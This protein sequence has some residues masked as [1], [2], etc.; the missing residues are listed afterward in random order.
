M[1]GLYVAPPHGKLVYKGK[2]TAV[3]KDRPWPELVGEFYLVSD[4]C[5]NGRAY[6][7]ITTQQEGPFTADEFR[8]KFNSHRVSSKEQARWWPDG[9]TFYLYT[10]KDFN[11]FAVPLSVEVPAG[12]QTIMSDVKFKEGRTL[13]PWKVF[14]RDGKFCVYKINDD[15]E[16]VGEALGCH[17]SESQARSQ[18]AALYAAESKNDSNLTVTKC[19][20]IET[21][22]DFVPFGVTSFTEMD[23]IEAA[24]AKQAE[25]DKRTIQLHQIIDNIAA[26]PAV[27]DKKAALNTVTNEYVE[28]VSETIGHKIGRRLNS[29]MLAV[30][31]QLKEGL[32]KLRKWAGYDEDDDD[33]GSKGISIKVLDDIF[34][35]FTTNSFID[36]EGEIFT[37]DSIEKLVARNSTKEVKGQVWYRHLPGSKFAHT[38]FQGIQGRFLIE[39]HRFDDTPVGQAMKALLNEHPNG[40]PEVCPEGWGCSHGY[41]YDPQDR[42]DSVYEWFDKQ[43]TSVLPA[44]VASNPYTKLE[45]LSMDQK[46]REEFEKLVGESIANEALSG[47]DELTKAL[48]G[49][50]VACKG[51]DGEAEPEVE[52]VAEAE[53]PEVAEAVEEAVE[54]PEA[55]APAV[56]EAEVVVEPTTEAEP[57]AEPVVEVAVDAEKIIDSFKKAI[58]FDNFITGWERLQSS[59]KALKDQNDQLQAELDS[60]KE[61]LDTVEQDDELRLFSKEAELPRFPWSYV[62][63]QDEDNEAQKGDKVLDSV[64]LQVNKTIAGLVSTMQ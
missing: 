33:N 9:D 42:K 22:A 19:V 36:R 59:N 40:H 3:A 49:A 56:E 50:G 8:A 45:V 1:N 14:S 54:A 16:P 17:E 64:P 28:R 55:E 13:M 44:S 62:P 15:D 12:V 24:R 34:V 26:D 32:E 10:I 48:E 61:R 39:V 7:T 51:A 11:P 31:D 41:Y 6:G 47:A 35:T 38:I 60:I 18:Q 29:S 46:A 4:G 30:V 25:T 58:D 37:A 57:A 43:E 2:K 20:G 63:S 27:V 53:T 52:E 5:K 23:D 21:R